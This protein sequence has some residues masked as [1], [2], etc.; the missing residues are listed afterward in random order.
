[1]RNIRKIVDNGTYTLY[2]YEDNTGRVIEAEI[3][4]VRARQMIDTLGE[5]L[6]KADFIR[7]DVFIGGL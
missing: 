5:A 1:M 3:A 4:D 2:S 6:Y 7:N